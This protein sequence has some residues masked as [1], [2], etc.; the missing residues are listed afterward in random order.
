MGVCQLFMTT[1]FSHQKKTFL[2]AD[3]L[4][5]DIKTKTHFHIFYTKPLLTRAEKLTW[6]EHTV[7][8]K[9]NTTTN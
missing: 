1:I 9:L 6:R 7:S 4:I 8:K 3:I 5:P 2:M